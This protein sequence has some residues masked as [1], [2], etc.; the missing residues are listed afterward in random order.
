MAERSTLLSALA[1]MLVLP[2][3]GIAIIWVIARAPD[4]HTGRV[5]VMFQDQPGDTI[6]YQRIA[7]SGARP[8]RVIGSVEGWIAEADT[9]RTVASLRQQFGA[10]HVFRDI[11]LGRALAG[12]LGL[13]SGPARPRGMIP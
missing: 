3:A 8:I 4:D 6:A 1:A 13:A 9:P 12:C 7:A 5:L 11:G 10:S 2:L